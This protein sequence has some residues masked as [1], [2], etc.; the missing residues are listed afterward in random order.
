MYVDKSDSLDCSYDMIIGRDLLE[1]L[2]IDFLFS[3]G[4]MIWDNAEVPMKPHG[5]FHKDNIDAYENEVL[6]MY[7]PDTKESERIQQI[8]DDKYTPGD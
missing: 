1:Q 2:G 6:F 8:L 3:K 5:S 7:D 4:M